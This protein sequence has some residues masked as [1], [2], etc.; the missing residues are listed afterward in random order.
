MVESIFGKL[1]NLSEMRLDAPE[2]LELPVWVILG[3]FGDGNLV[4]V[5]ISN[6]LVL[7]VVYAWCSV[8]LRALAVLGDN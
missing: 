5:S 4:V 3:L 1:L 2:D 7:R 6:G 8:I